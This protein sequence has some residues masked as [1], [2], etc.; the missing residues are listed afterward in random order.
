MLSAHTLRSASFG[1]LFLAA[2][3]VAVP[4]R[5]GWAQTYSNF[6]GGSGNTLWSNPA[7]WLDGVVPNNNG[8]GAYIG[9]SAVT[10]PTLSSSA[11]ITN[12]YHNKIQNSTIE[13][14]NNAQLT[15][16]GGNQLL[17]TAYPGDFNIKPKVNI[18]TSGEFFFALSGGN[19][20]LS[21]GMSLSPGVA[22][23]VNHFADGKTLAITGNVTLP[24]GSSFTYNDGPT[25]LNYSAP[26][27]TMTGSV[28][29]F[30]KSG[31]YTLNTTFWSGSTGT[32]VFNGSTSVTIN[33]LVYPG[34]SA[35]IQ[36]GSLV[37]GPNG[38]FSGI[39][40][41]NANLTLNGN[42]SNVMDNLMFG[43]GSLT[44]N[45]LGTL[46]L[47]NPN[48]SYTGPTNV[49]GG[50][51]MPT[52]ATAIPSG[53][54]VNLGVSA[55]LDMNGFNL[56]IGGLEGG[57]TVRN[58]AGSARTLTVGANNASTTFS[59]NID[60]TGASGSDIINLVKVG[61][62]RLTLTGNN[63][64]AG[65]AV[66]SAGTLRIGHPSTVALSFRGPIVNNA[67]LEYEINNASIVSTQAIS[68]SGSVNKLGNGG[69][70]L[71]GS[72]SYIGPT[73]VSAGTLQIGNGGNVSS[74]SGPITNNANLV[75]SHSNTVTLGNLSG[76]GSLVKQGTGTLMVTGTVSQAG[77]ITINGGT[78]QIGAANMSGHI[79]NPIVNNATLA[80]ARTDNYTLPARLTGSGVF[81]KTEGSTLRFATGQPLPMV[82]G[83]VSITGGSI[84][85]SDNDLILT[86]MA[87]PAVRSLVGSWWNSGQRNGTGLISSL[88]VPGS[89]TTLGVTSAGALG[90]SSY[91]T[92]S[93]SPSSVIVKYTYLGDT[94]LSGRVDATD[95]QNLIVGLRAN[96][97]GWRNGDT[98]YDGVVN[99]NDLANLLTTM[100][101]QGAP[102]DAGGG[103]FGGAIPEPR[104]LLALL[105]PSMFLRRLRR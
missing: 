48:S 77:G 15:L 34:L 84:D 91:N 26:T 52:A 46:R 50:T 13:V 86:A 8:L 56:S 44:K 73:T 89:V 72:L 63:L 35:V 24:S 62:G 32:L 64:T 14:Q 96:L 25:T 9:N 4:S 27:T 90:I 7:N 22:L 59:G 30:R 94:N 2:A 103:G 41:N 31:N 82:Q 20:T 69:L 51:L 74:L 40:Q 78:L 10:S 39:I 88:A 66:I 11:S 99:G 55:S 60:G 5:V 47:A 53:S 28:M 37:I 70:V 102:L 33:T 17:V 80:V 67:A 38:F 42:D 57:G 68:G 58:N 101:L 3:S 43:T 19:V 85:L 75:F 21:G 92:V 18:S 100:R 23:A 12:L 104:A 65:S 49:N 16:T 97:T 98:N 36:T 93:V 61:N 79:T 105:T 83:S 6:I 71:S 76:T 1:A 45:G 95:L 29:T 54:T 87:E 81:L